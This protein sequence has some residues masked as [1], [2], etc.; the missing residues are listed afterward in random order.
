VIELISVRS[1]REIDLLRMAGRIVYETHQYLKPFLKEGI[2]TK[3]IDDLAAEFIKSKGA[4]PSCKGYQGYPANIC[5]SINDE[6]VHG[7]AGKRKLKN[8]DIVTL[9]ICACYKGYHGDSAWSYAVGEISDDA[10]YIMEHTEKALYEG[11]KMAK[12]GNR[13]GDISHAVEEYAN[14]YHLGVIKELTGHGVGSHLHEEPN[15]PNYG[16]A[17]TGPKLKEGMV[18]AIEPM[19]TLGSE[20]IDIDDNGLT[21]YTLDGSNAAHYEH[22]IAIT[23]DGPIILTG[24]WEN[25]KE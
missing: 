4:T 5:I 23:K 8:G 19:L 18:I 1:E 9:D 15:V 10:K 3:E 6:V 11:L 12:A 24:E 2:S 21:A 14:R 17:G 22:T 20:E 13:V 7:I 25:G 16:R